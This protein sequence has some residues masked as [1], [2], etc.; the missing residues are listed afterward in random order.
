MLLDPRRALNPKAM[1]QQWLLSSS[2]WR[3]EFICARVP[4]T[5]AAVARLSLCEATAYAMEQN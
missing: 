1:K 4:E 2:A 5:S 3:A